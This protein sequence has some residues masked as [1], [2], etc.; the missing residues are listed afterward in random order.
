MN[1]LS[2]LQPKESPYVIDDWFQRLSSSFE[3]VDGRTTDTRVTGILL[4]H[5]GAFGSG[6]LKATAYFSHEIIFLL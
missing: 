3:N 6:V 4:A 1:K 2:F 5:P